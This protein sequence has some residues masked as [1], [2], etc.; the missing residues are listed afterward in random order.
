MNIDEMIATYKK[1]NSYF[2][3]VTVDE[4]AG[5]PILGFLVMN[6]ANFLSLKTGKRF[7]LGVLEDQHKCAFVV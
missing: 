3:D 5:Y 4:A 1:M 7:Y 2:I 6:F